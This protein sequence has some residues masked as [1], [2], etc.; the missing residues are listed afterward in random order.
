MA[1]YL[2]AGQLVYKQ[3]MTNGIENCLCRVCGID[4]RF[5]NRRIQALSILIHK[6]MCYNYI[7]RMNGNIKWQLERVES[8]PVA[9]TIV[10]M[11]QSRTVIISR[12]PAL[13]SYEP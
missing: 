10:D 8:H 5:K 11:K 12:E 7:E 6:S 2:K 1:E 4:E 3:N 13:A 9:K